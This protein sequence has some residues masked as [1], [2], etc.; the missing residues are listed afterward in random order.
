M[1]LFHFSLLFG[2]FLSKACAKVAGI[3]LDEKAVK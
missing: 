1:G 2:T 3:E